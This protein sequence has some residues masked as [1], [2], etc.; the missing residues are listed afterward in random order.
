MCA[1]EHEYGSHALPVLLISMAG[2]VAHTVE[3]WRIFELLA[4]AHLVATIAAMDL[5]INDEAS[6]KTWSDALP[7]LL[8]ESVLAK[9]I[10][11]DLGLTPYRLRRVSGKCPDVLE[12]NPEYFMGEGALSPSDKS[13][14]ADLC[15]L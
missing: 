4:A 9:K 13:S 7:E 3:P 10:S 15:H 2:I 12:N 1:A 11:F 6:I 8:G 14:S 5:A